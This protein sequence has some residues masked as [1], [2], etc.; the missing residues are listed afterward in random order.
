MPA[1]P[2]R[3]KMAA[4][5]H[6]TWLDESTGPHMTVSWNYNHAEIIADGIVHAVGAAL[7]IAG[8]AVLLAIAFRFAPGAEIGAVVVYVIACCRCW[9]FP[10]PIIS[11]RYRRANGCCAA[12]T[13]HRSIC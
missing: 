6:F 13:I 8:A 4:I 7:G 11:G 5:A 3:R 1:P 12:S 2:M 9:A 10:W